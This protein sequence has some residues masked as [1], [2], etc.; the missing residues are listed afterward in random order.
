MTGFNHID[1]HL[2][3]H[4]QDKARRA[5][6][7][8]R[9]QADKDNEE[10]DNNQYDLMRYRADQDNEVFDAY[11][12]QLPILHAIKAAVPAGRAVVV[13]DG[14]LVIDGVEV[15]YV[16]SFREDWTKGYGVMSRGAKPTGKYRIV[17]GNYG[18]DR[19]QF[20]QRKDGT[21]NYVEIARL[22]VDYVD[23]T[24]TKANL[25]RTRQKNKR[26]VEGLV[27]DL[28]LEKYQNI[29]S[30]SQNIDNPVHVKI[31]IERAMTTRK[32][33]ALIEA[34]REHGFELKY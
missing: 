5:A 27:S 21:H 17:V 34:L 19:R 14:S 11:R 22:L 1:E 6:D 31:T 8:L 18:S 10:F 24:K 7:A 29:V 4:L 28:G 26:Y 3:E 13:Q 25:E 33:K 20:P 9:E 30:A 23:R 2:E 12:K 15:R 16:L 32:A